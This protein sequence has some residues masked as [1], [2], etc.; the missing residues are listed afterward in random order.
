MSPEYQKHVFEPFTQENTAVQSKYGGTGLGM[1]I[2]KGLVDKM[3]GTII[4][5]SEK[6]VGTTFVITIPFE[7]AE[8]QEEAAAAA[9]GGTDGEGVKEGEGKREQNTEPE[10]SPSI[11]GYHILLAEDNELNMEI[12]EF[13]LEQAGAVVQK[14]WNGDE[15]V[16]IFERSQP[17]EFDAILMDLMMPAVDGYEATGRIRSMDRADAKTVPIIAMTANAFTED[18]IRTR[19]A[20]M[21]AHIIKPIDSASVIEMVYKLVKISRNMKRQKEV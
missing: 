17:G 11:S 21:N 8:Q 15:A 1:S 13:V 9:A 16:N 5:E 7:I 3:H 2:V 18:R 19:K 14:A 4:M 10:A 6:D 20:G 12:A